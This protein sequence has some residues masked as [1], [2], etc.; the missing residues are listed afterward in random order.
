[1][2]PKVV[3]ASKLTTES[4]GYYFEMRYEIPQFETVDVW[5]V[6]DVVAKSRMRSVE[7]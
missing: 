3:F 1:M 7:V 4:Y 5:H 6:V 2:F